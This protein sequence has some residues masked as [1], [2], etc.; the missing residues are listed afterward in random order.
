MWNVKPGGQTKT[1]G[2]PSLNSIVALLI[3]AGDI[4]RRII[5]FLSWISSP[6]LHTWSRSFKPLL[7]GEKVAKWYCL[8]YSLYIIRVFTTPRR[9]YIINTWWGPYKSD[10]IWKRGILWILDVNIV[11]VTNIFTFFVS[12]NVGVLCQSEAPGIEVKRNPDQ[13]DNY[14]HKLMNVLSLA[15]LLMLGCI[16]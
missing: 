8:L 9:T 3:W 2:F 4:M 5:G 14:R 11:L 7:R 13:K 6:S 1:K 10:F 12:V 16:Y 15:Y